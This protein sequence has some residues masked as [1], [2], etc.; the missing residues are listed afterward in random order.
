M[1]ENK[2]KQD[3]KDNSEFQ[4]F[5]KKIEKGID[6][7]LK[8]IEQG[9]GTPAGQ[10]FKEFE[11]KH[12]ISNEIN[13]NRKYTNSKKIKGKVNLQEKVVLRETGENYDKE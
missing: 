4:D 3:L 8:E 11:Q 12:E 10:Y 2:K 9:L 1:Q 13:C 7:G 5:I 6:K